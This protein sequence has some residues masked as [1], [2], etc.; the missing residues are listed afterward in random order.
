MKDKFLTLLIGA[1]VFLGLTT[2]IWAVASTGIGYWVLFTAMILV[3]SYAVGWLVRDIW[4]LRR[5]SR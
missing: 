4:D 2:I 1:A 5:A 3:A